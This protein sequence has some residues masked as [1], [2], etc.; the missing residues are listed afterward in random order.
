MDSKEHWEKVYTTKPAESVS[1][2][3]QHA[4]TSL[5]L[6][7]HT[8]VTPRGHII[9]VGG[10]ASTLIDDLIA[11]GFCN[12]SVLDLSEVALETAQSRLG[13]K[14]AKVNWIVGD[15]TAIR[16]PQS[17][18][19]IWHDRAVFHFLI[20]AED[21]AAYK[22]ILEHSLK[23]DGH[24]IMATFAE[25]GPTQCSGL[26]VKRYSVAELEA[27]IG[28]HFTLVRAKKEQHVT[29]SGAIQNFNY[30]HFRRSA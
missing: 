22:A 30:C 17:C 12:V 15:I 3:Q 16:L 11:K 29:P 20:N 26:A 4:S 10:G 24:L 2:F 8:G 14:A 9:D 21:R 5:E 18:Y 13:R 1:W 28:S 27:E 25:D 23:P 7:A 6:I 19:D